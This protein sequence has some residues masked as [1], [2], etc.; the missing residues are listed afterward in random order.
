MMISSAATKQAL[1]RNSSNYYSS[2]TTNYCYYATVTTTNQTTKTGVTNALI[3]RD[4]SMINRV[5]YLGRQQQQN[6]RYYHHHNYSCGRRKGFQVQQKLIHNSNKNV[7]Y[8]S[9]SRRTMTTTTTRPISS[10]FRRW[11][12]TN[13]SSGRRSPHWLVWVSSSSLLLA[14]MNYY[15]WNK[16]KKTNCSAA[17]V[18]AQEPSV[19]DE[20]EILSSWQRIRKKARKA[21]R[22]FAR[23]VKLYI[24]LTPLLFLYPLLS[25]ATTTDST[26]STTEKKKKEYHWFAQWYLR[27][28]LRN[29]EWSGAA[30]IKL[31]QWLSSRPDLV[32]D[33]FCSVFSCLQDATT[34]HHWKHTVAAMEEAYGPQWQDRLRLEPV[35]IGSGCIGQV[36]KGRLIEDKK[37]QVVAV[38]VLH[39]NIEKDIETDLDWLNLVARSLPLIS[40]PLISLNPVGCVEEFG[41]MLRNQLDLREEAHNLREFGKLFAS[42]SDY[43]IFPEVIDTNPHTKRVLV[44][45]YIEGLPIL[46][47]AKHHADDYDLLHRLCRT[48]IKVVC[49]MIFVHNRCHGDLHPGNILITPDKKMALLDCGIVNTYSPEDHDLIVGVLTSFIRHDGEL[50]G[51]MLLRHSDAKA[52][53]F[54][55]TLQRKN[56]R[57]LGID[58]DGFV[59]KINSI[60]IRSQSKEEDLMENLGA[61]ISEIC[62]AAAQHRV[63]MNESFVS[64]MLA[65]KVQ[66]G[67]VLALDPGLEIWKVA[68]P[69]ILEGEARRKAK[70]VVD[71]VKESS[72]SFP[73]NIFQTKTSSATD[74]TT[75]S[76]RD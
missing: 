8:Y 63:L 42:E 38:K 10:S 33:E 2:T 60:A 1:L 66:E 29:V 39:P 73:W 22:M 71:K 27:F 74:D 62:N 75:S 21:L 51:R 32:G 54:S 17:A 70:Q 48:G 58:E 36:Y 61:Y 34:P 31:M 4:G 45:S 25:S 11:L 9:N 30:V 44:E 12:I 68:N 16:D 56:T 7:R 43:L 65:I 40:K 41:R 46:E 18:V 15:N 19:I 57:L 23:L 53:A 52:K 69:I 14:T 20:E 28:C 55:K 13:S 47:Y 50:A 72:S 37:E 6:Q 24:A 49:K 35:P 59:A 67:I 26:D 64:A 3:G 76:T 5:L